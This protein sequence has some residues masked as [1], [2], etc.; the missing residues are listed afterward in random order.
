MGGGFHGGF[1]RTD[2][3]VGEN[4]QV[5]PAKYS[6]WIGVSKREQLLKK[7]NNSKLRNAVSE[8]YRKGSFIGDGGTAAVLKFEKRTGLNTG[9]RGKNHYQKAVD[10]SRYL[11][12]KVLKEQLSNSER[13]AAEKMLKKLGKAIAEWRA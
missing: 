3:Y 11:S 10:M 2:F 1:G 8:L 5:L 9:Y 6:K 12:N 7:A 4:G 13:R